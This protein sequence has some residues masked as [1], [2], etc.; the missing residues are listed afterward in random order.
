EAKIPN[1]VPE[2]ELRR[3]QREDQ[4]LSPA[5]ARQPQL[6]EHGQT[7]ITL[8][9]FQQRNE[10]SDKRN[11]LMPSDVE[12]LSMEGGKI[13]HTLNLSASRAYDSAL[14]ILGAYKL[15]GNFH[16]NLEIILKDIDAIHKVT[17]EIEP[18]SLLPYS[19]DRRQVLF[20]PNQNICINEFSE[21][22]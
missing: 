16:I 19:P 6:A 1:A 17:F 8:A 7:L 4:S 3:T 21:I 9:R 12:T 5:G 11:T 10:R 15:T 22:M 20:R 13:G 2:R 14:D 18:R